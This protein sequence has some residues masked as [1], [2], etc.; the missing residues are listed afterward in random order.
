ML[1]GIYLHGAISYMEATFPWAIHDRH[2]SVFFDLSVAVIHGFRMQLFFVLA[3]FFARMVH[4]RMGTVPFI[5]RRW[6]RIGLPFV[7]GLVTLLPLVFVVW[8]WGMMVSGQL[9]EGPLSESPKTLL[10]YPTGHLWFLEYLM[11]FYLFLWV[12][13]PLARLLNWLG[14]VAGFEIC[15]R[16]LVQS[17]WK[18]LLLPFL[19][20]PLL[21]LGPMI[22][23]SETVGLSLLP[24]M[25][26]LVYYGVFF[27]FGWFVQRDRPT[28]LSMANFPVFNCLVAGIA[29]LVFAG[30]V[31]E[32][33]SRGG[34]HPG[35]KIAGNWAA[36]TYAWAMIFLTIGLALRYFQASRSWVRYLADAA[37]WFYL[38]HL[39]LVIALQV[40]MAKWDVN[41]FVKCALV[42]VG[43]LLV[44]WATYDWL[45]RYTWVGRMLNGLRVRPER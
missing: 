11:F 29:F 20:M 8:G 17:R 23:E 30:C 12:R 36:A 4:D 35:L 18:L 24:S 31:D 43:S 6:Q 10:D 14:V 33:M 41:A 38:A 25:G 44:L 16:W 22:G 27:G 13:L 37:Y 15:F 2:R 34:R 19:T 45:V 9:P 40:A 3:G 21:M 42:N 1:A 5:R 32:V 39:P 26:G 28:W 7:I